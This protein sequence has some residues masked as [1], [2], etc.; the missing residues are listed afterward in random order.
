[1]TYYRCY[2]LDHG[3]HIYDFIDFAKDSDAEA[4]AHARRACPSMIG[5]GFELWQEC[6]LV[7]RQQRGGKSVARRPPSARAESR[8]LT[9][10]C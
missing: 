4:I 2:F 10:G 5:N 9:R 6:R 1:M 7:D 8:P 3:D